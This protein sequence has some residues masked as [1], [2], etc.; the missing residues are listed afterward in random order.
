M[1]K[2]LTLRWGKRSRNNAPLERGVT[3][4]ETMIAA[5]ILLIVVAEFCLSSPSVFK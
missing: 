4:I 5:A 2:E 3:M 1:A